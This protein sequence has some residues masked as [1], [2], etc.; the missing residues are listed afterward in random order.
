MSQ[1][2][3]IIRG[4]WKCWYVV[5]NMNSHLGLVKLLHLVGEWDIVE[6]KLNRWMDADADVRME[7]VSSQT[8]D[9]AAARRW[10]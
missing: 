9:D 7:E 1:T 5:N 10:W 3:R 6:S 2:N 4:A 8:D